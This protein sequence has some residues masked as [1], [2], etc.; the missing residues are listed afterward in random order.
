MKILL[1]MSKD[2]TWDAACRKELE[3][4]AAKLAER[5]ELQEDLYQAHEDCRMHDE[6]QR[7][8]RRED[9]AKDISRWECMRFEGLPLIIRE[10]IRA[11]WCS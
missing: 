11:A 9:R 8:Y 10:R 2:E 1:L 6:V 3:V 5:E 7:L 4:E